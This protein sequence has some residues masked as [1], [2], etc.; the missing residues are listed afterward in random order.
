MKRK[1]LSI[2]PLVLKQ[3]FGT[4]SVVQKKVNF[5]N[6]SKNEGLSP[7]CIALSFDGF[8]SISRLSV[9]VFIGSFT[10]F[11]FFLDFQLF[12]PELH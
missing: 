5:L 8:G 11:T 7:S 1:R 3:V 10:V 12:R 4:D 2:L 9:L 6:S